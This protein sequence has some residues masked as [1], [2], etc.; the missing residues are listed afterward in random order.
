VRYSEDID[1]DVIVVPKDTL[2]K[3]VEGLLRSPLVAAP[4][5]TK[6]I[7][8]AESSAPKQTE[9]TQRWKVGLHVSGVSVPLRTKIEFSRRSEA[10]V[11]ARF[12][13]TPPDLLRPY[14]LTPILATHYAAHAAIVQNL[15]ALAGRA[16]PQARDV[17]DA[18][19]LLAR[20][21]ASGLALTAAQRAWVPKAVHHA[22]SVSYDE[23]IAKVVAYLEPSQAELFAGRDTWDAMQCS[24]VSL[25]EAHA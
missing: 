3:K 18:S 12:E 22:M 19:L 14:G 10:I 23:Y 11:G 21:D 24:V 8:L 2:F 15:H 20:T 1:F 6:G 5:K 9:T 4:L 7:V 17:F 16:E 25:L 13:A